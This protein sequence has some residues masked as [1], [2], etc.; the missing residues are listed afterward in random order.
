MEIAKKNNWTFSPIITHRLQI[1]LITKQYIDEI[2][3]E[4]NNSEVNIYLANKSAESIDALDARINEI[5][6]KNQNHEIIQLQSVDKLNKEFLWLCAIKKPKTLHPEIWL[7][8]KKWA[9]G[10]WYGKELVTWLLDRIRNNLEY[11]YIVYETFEDNIWSVSI[12]ESLWGI[13]YWEEEK[14]NYFW[15]KMKHIHYRIYKT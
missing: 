4:K 8:F 12:I 9:R 3:T 10:K 13:K 15:E 2:F 1:E 11:E 14:I 5:M 6:I 7:R